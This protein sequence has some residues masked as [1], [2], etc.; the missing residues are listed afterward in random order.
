[1]GRCGGAPDLGPALRRVRERQ[2]IARVGTSGN[3]P[4]RNGRATRPST[5]HPSGVKERSGHPVKSSAEVNLRRYPSVIMTAMPSRICSLPRPLAVLTGT[6]LFGL[7]N[8]SF[9]YFAG[10][11]QSEGYSLGSV[12]GQ[13]GWDPYS[14]ALV[15][16][17]QSNPAGQQSLDVMGWRSAGSLLSDSGIDLWDLGTST[18]ILK[19]SFDFFAPGFMD[20]PADK[21]QHIHC[22]LRFGRYGSTPTI[23]VNVT[24]IGG[25]TQVDYLYNLDAGTHEKAF[26]VPIND[27]SW[28]RL[29]TYCDFSGATYTSMLDDIVLGQ[30]TFNSVEFFT[31]KIYAI[32][33]GEYGT[34]N[35][36]Q[37]QAYI[38]NLNIVAVP[39]PSAITLLFLCPLLRRRKDWRSRHHAV[40]ERT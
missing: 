5:R 1:M 4:E 38:D 33:L 11:E 28:H 7:A 30:D 37:G 20:I 39:E 32:N 14:T 18:H 16:N 2:L 10:F 17:S 22:D 25:K 29:T 31:N 24:T 15:S 9:H 6:L 36:F 40:I 13:N 21:D 23:H 35:F 19:Y 3:R 12:G 27:G 26:I 8:A 34:Y